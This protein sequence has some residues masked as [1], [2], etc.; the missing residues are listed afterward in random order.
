MPKLSEGDVTLDVSNAYESYRF[1]PQGFRNPN[2]NHIYH[3]GK[4]Y[5]TAGDVNEGH[6]FVLD[7]VTKVRT[8]INLYPLGITAE[9]ETIFIWNGQ[10][11]I[12]CRS[13]I[14]I[15]MLYFE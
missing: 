12:A 10:F 4:L 6:V 15:Y 3:D 9:P 14:N 1:P 7:L 13:N 11:C 2:Q 8:T 5:L